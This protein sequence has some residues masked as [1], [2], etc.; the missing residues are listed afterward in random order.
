MAPNDDKA[1]LRARDFWT[2]IALGALSVF[3]L[4][5]T[6][7]VWRFGADRAGVSGSH[8]YD[9]AALVPFG[10]FG[11]LLVLALALMWTSIRD[12]GAARAL[13]RAGIGWDRHEAVR[14]G[15]IAVIL[16]FYI[17]GLMPRVD[18]IIASGLLITALIYGFHGGQS[19][20]MWVAA[21]VTAG[22]G[23]YALVRHLPQSAWGAHDDDVVA[24]AAWAGLTVW[25]L[26]REPR[27]RVTRIMPVL[28]A[29]A[30]FLLVCT[31]AFGFRQNVPNRVGLVFSK[32]EYHYYVTLKPLWAD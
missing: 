24:L 1:V 27:D 16:F 30:P 31:M 20:R 7:L 4:W 17:A 22:P 32:I 8:W 29:V 19:H 9:S 2:S 15:T 26:V 12:G 13:S 21:A 6:V 11:L 25:A 18:F 23:L 14:F 10:I 28:A 3:F 5:R